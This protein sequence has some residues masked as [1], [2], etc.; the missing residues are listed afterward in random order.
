LD[1]VALKSQP[2][3]YRQQSDPR[4]VSINAC[5][6]VPSARRLVLVD[7]RTRCVATIPDV[8]L[9]FDRYLLRTQSL[10]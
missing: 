5:Q 7:I 3:P 10:L 8:D 2:D 6:S 9:H 1:S 4:S